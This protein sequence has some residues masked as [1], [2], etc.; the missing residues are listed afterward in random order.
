MILYS[1]DGAEPAPLPFRIV[2]PDGR[3]RTDPTTFTP[4]EIA[5]AGFVETPGVP[6]H[7]SA[8]QHVPVWNGTGYDV[9]DKT[10]QEITDEASAAL[11][12]AKANLKEAV[13]E[14]SD[15]KSSEGYEHDFGADG[16]HVLQT[17]LSDRA[18]WTA[19]AT[20][21]H[22]M[23]LGGQPTAPVGTIRTEGNV[24]IPV[25]AET[26]HTAMVAMQAHLAAVIRHGWALKDQVN[27]AVD[28]AAVEAIDFEAGWPATPAD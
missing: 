3:T 11:A 25:T 19:L 28:V 9:T 10:A 16:V 21:C 8:T 1:K 17:R 4:A 15:R 12:E 26:A 6:A 13:Q 23:M 27:A 7:D 2:L 18:N 5:D 22:A 14:L 24:N 20:L